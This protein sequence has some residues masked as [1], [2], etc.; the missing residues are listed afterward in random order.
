MAALNTVHSLRSFGLLALLSGLIMG[1][2]FLIVLLLQAGL[3]P[4]ALS[5][6]FFSYSA[7]A[8]VVALLIHVNRLA[9][10]ALT[11]IWCSS[12]LFSTD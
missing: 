6:S 3:V 1:P 7:I 9:N 12:T 10:L 5:V 4:P 11:L 2:S 8:A